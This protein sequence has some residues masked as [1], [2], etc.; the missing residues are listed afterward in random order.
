MHLRFIVA[1]VAATL[2]FA[3]NA[4]A[5]PC[6]LPDAKPLWVDYAESTVGFRDELFRRPGLVLASSGTTTPQKRPSCS[7]AQ[8]P[9]PAAPPR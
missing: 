3:P 8:P 2:V 9:P 1:T 6:G 7:T 5:G 4:L